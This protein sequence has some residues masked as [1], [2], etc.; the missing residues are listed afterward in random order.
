MITVDT[1]ENMDLM[2]YIP[3]INSSYVDEIILDPPY[4]KVVNEKWDNQWSSLADYIDWFDKI[5]N[6]LDRV[7]KRSCSL[8]IFGFPYQLSFI[9]PIVENNGFLYKQTIILNRD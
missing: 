6:E 9:I 7:S 8:W 1:I 4:F 3:K 2:D 5:M